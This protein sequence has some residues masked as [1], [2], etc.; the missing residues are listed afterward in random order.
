[1]G[2]K[3]PGQGAKTR[4]NSPGGLQCGHPTKPGL[5]PWLKGRD[6]TAGPA[7]KVEQA[8]TPASAGHGLGRRLGLPGPWA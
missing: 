4:R 2:A 7:H 8:A 1:M 5:G 6:P 3:D